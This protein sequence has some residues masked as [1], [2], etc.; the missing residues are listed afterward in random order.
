MFTF[1]F[2]TVCVCAFTEF[3]SG[4]AVH[5]IIVP[6]EVIVVFSIQRTE[7]GYLLS[8]ADLDSGEPLLPDRTSIR[9][10]G[11]RQSTVEFDTLLRGN[12]SFGALLE[13]YGFS[14]VPSP[15]YRGPG[16]G[17]PYFTGQYLTREHGS[18]GGGTIDAIQVESARPY[19][20][21]SII[22]RY[23]KA[24]ACA[25]RDY[26]CMYYLPAGEGRDAQPTPGCE[27][28]YHR[29]CSRPTSTGCQLAISLLWTGVLLI[30]LLFN[31][32]FDAVGWA[33]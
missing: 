5:F 21:S 23:A 24:L 22:G 15:T 7:L 13:V 30:T 32:R 18:L 20:D 10:L 26:V 33:I 4:I 19:R 1:A 2:L 9:Y 6:H 17:N 16:A 8:G 27:E 3:W 12:I 28:Q 25:M 11:E 31:A 29:L 14:A